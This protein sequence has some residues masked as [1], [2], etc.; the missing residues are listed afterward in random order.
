M[1]A[2]LPDLFATPNV[3][4]ESVGRNGT[5]IVSTETASDFMLRL[6]TAH[7]LVNLVELE[8]KIDNAGKY[9]YL[10]IHEIYKDYK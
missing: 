10:K 4:V 8:S 1:Q 7:N 3:K 9:T 5:T 2:A 6:C